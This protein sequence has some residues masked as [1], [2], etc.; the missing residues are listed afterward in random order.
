MAPPSIY[1]ETEAGSIAAD[2]DGAPDAPKRNP[3][4]VKKI[5]ANKRNSMGLPYRSGG[6][7]PRAGWRPLSPAQLSDTLQLQAM[8]CFY[9]SFHFPNKF[10]HQ[11]AA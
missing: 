11:T 8:I 10:S 2:G 9:R 3:V 1:P 5:A 4:D 6:L 7:C